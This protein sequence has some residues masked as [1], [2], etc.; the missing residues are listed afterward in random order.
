MNT[1]SFYANKY[2]HNVLKL[3]GFIHISFVMTGIQSNMIK[4]VLWNAVQKYSTMLVTLVVTMVMAR[5]LSPENFGVVA[6]AMV[7]INFL[8]IF[9]SMGIGPAII[10]RKDLSDNDIN[11]IYSFSVYV[12]ILLSI[13]LFFAS[14]PIA[15][16]YENAI[17]KSVCQILCINVFFSTINMVPTALM[18]K[19]KR[20]KEMAIR[21]L[22]LSIISGVVSVVGAYYGLG[23]YSL[24]I[25]PIL[26]AIG[27]YMY[28]IHYYPVTFH[29]R[30]S[31]E[32]LRKIY[33]YSIYQFAFQ[34]VGFFSLNL[35]RLIIGK[36]I[37]PVS[38]GYYDKAHTLVKLPLSS[39]SGIVTPVLHPFLSDYQTE[40]G[41][42][43]NGHNK[44]V[45][46]LTSISLPITVILYFCGSELI[47]VLFGSQWGKSVMTFQIL[48][49]S[50]TPNMILSTSGAFW[51][52]TN[53]TKYLFWTGLLNS[54]VIILGYIFSSSV[55]GTIE[56][57]AAV[58]VLTVYVVFFI[59]YAIMYHR[60]FK[61]S[62]RE[63][64]FICLNPMI[65]ALL[66]IVFY[67]VILLY[68]PITNN[69]ISLIIKLLVGVVVTFVF[70][71]LSGRYDIVSM[72][73]SKTITF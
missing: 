72:I 58:Y 57:M 39:L 49:L 20:F 22:V 8:N 50:L 29:I 51:Q 68:F 13:L 26:S 45:K 31:F 14:W 37:S 24:L 7:A 40:I 43:R 66:L 61:A 41:I 46:L 62:L 17:L 52:S 32:P 5:I 64:L 6:I 10:Q 15:S 44:I 59:T 47:E 33:S 21:S 11:H 25:T 67:V 35:D 3:T 48:T 54:T 63:M 27:L 38:L 23:I 28:N 71:Q 19:H 73:K 65:N 56:A 55:F 34:F 42:I 12:A 4:G 70:L 60:V 2:L 9:S 1:T 53:C 36:S 69:I 18:S 30:F 16:Y